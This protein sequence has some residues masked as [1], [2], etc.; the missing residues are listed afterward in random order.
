MRNLLTL[1]LTFAVFFSVCRPLSAQD[2]VYTD[3]SAFPIYGK[4]S[5]GTEGRYERLPSYLKGISRDPVWYLGTN[6]A[7][8]FI[9]FRSNSTS[10]HARWTSTY[11]NAMPHMTDTGTRGLDL[12]A[13]VNG[14]WM[15]VC[16]AQPQGGRSERKIIGNM[17]PVEREYMLYLS[18]YDGVKSLEIGVDKGATLDLP[19]VDSPKREK[20]VVMYGTSILQG[21]CANRPGMAHT[22]ILSRRLDREVINLGFSGNALLDM[23]I[24]HLMASVEDPGAFVLDYAP[25]AFADMIDEKG[26]AFFRVI[27]D[28]HPDVPVVFIEDVIFPHTKFDNMIRAE[29]VSKNEAQKRLFGKLKKA[30]EKNIYY[31]GAEG[32]IGDDGEATVD[33]IHFTDLGAMRYV[34]H[35]LPVIRKALKKGDKVKPLPREHVDVLVIGGGASGISAAIQSARMGV[36]TMVAEETPWIGGMLTSAG[37]SC[38]DGNYNLRSGLFGEFTDSLAVRYGG[39]DA[40]KTGWVSNINYEPNVGQEIF[41]N[42]AAACG[43]KLE[44]RRQTRMTD[45]R[46]EGALWKVTL[47]GADGKM[48]VVTADVLIDGTELGDVAKACGVEYRI[49]M[50]ASSQTG[51]SIAP[52]EANGV[53]QDLTYVVMLKDYGPDADMTIDMPE[54]YDPAPFYNSAL[55]PKN[56]DN[57]TGQT[58]WSPQMMI[59]YGKTPNGRYMINWPIY[60]NDYY[61]NTIEMTRE[62]RQEAYARAK[63]FTLQFV[64]FIQTELGMKN[65]GIADDVFP[66]EDGLALFPYHRES[67]RIVGEAFFT[68]DAAAAPYSYEYPYYRTGIAVGDYAV[69]H[70]HFRHPDWR[71]LPDLEFYPIP[72]YN[73]PMGVLLPKQDDVKNLIVAEKSVSVSNLING[74]TRLQ[75]VVMQLGQA[76][77]VI[78]ALSQYAGVD[79]KEV[80][81]RK[82][83]SALLEAG[84]Y[85]MPYLDLP[86]DHRHFKAL[87]RIGATGI[88]RGE[89]RNVGWANQTWF[90]ADEPLMAEEIFDSGYGI[91]DEGPVTIDELL[92]AVFGGE[93][94]ASWEEWWTGLGLENYE[95]SR[96]ITRLEAAVVIDSELDDFMRRDVDFDGNFKE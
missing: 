76:A 87:Q 67:R 3:A 10:I 5:D 48:S 4:V 64:Y 94:P 85:I 82:V 70:H 77:G 57:A 39:W 59:T 89:G 20:P 38:I 21:G 46:K 55:N 54:G 84:C 36:R 72:S 25:N 14:E 62:E 53:I 12:Y 15:H 78:A 52:K 26:E 11:C 32:M 49:G 58:I 92:N 60:G 65:L 93:T 9:R 95:P 68:V 69:D 23:E 34:D 24:A 88:L 40:L 35:I 63:N 91:L 8:L 28:A 2:V 74:A 6:S 27:R 7:G 44:V 45:V 83:Q 17:E 75:P 80:G 81:V 47:E 33:A 19:A 50:E 29:V 73:V 31:I 61:V 42:M 13:L 86:K 18:L 41:T 51:E 66:T 90:R 22:N 79:V 56:T 43:S 71:N 30:G 37:V 96:V 16:S 1:A